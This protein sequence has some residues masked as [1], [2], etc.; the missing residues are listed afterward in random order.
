MKR[1]DIIIPH[2]HL[3]SVNKLLRRHK[4]GGMSFYD[5]KGRGKAKN[6]PISVGRGVVTYVPEF[7]Y[8]TKVEVVVPDAVAKAIV[9]DILKI[10]GTGASA[11]GKI[12][13]FDVEE[14]YDL[15]SGDTGDT[16]L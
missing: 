6:Q 4:V 15:G 13:V 2:E 14:A 10:L 9:R 8:R 11:I 7:G 16:A 1:L 12:F 5:V 3:V